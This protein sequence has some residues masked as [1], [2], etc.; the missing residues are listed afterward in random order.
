MYDVLPTIANMFGFKEKWSLG[1][2]IFSIIPNVD[3][4][5]HGVKP[6]IMLE[7][8]NNEF[9]L[10]EDELDNIFI[11][12]SNVRNILFTEIILLNF[13]IFHIII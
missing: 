3:N 2:D 4:L 12:K 8:S 1:N 10:K 13:D 11:P 7:K 5:F 9:E 6:S